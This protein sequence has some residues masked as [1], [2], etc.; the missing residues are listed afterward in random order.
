MKGKVWAAS[1]SPDGRRIVTASLDKTARVW[2]AE[3]GKPMGEPMRHE[4]EVYTA[5]FSSD[6]RRVVTASRD[7]HGCGKRRAA[8]Q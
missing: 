2:E 1:F 8:G 5:N 3:S 7:S 6:G 4:G